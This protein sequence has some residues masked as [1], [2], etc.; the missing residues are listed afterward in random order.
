MDND[1]YPEIAEMAGVYGERYQNFNGNFKHS[2]SNQI[3][4]LTAD[5]QRSSFKPRSRVV[6]P[7]NRYTNSDCPD[8][9]GTSK[10]FLTCP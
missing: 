6:R 8:W 4:R 10:I 7:K 3:L 9:F 1:A 2:S 5:A